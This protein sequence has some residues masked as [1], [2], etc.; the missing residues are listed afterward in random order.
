MLEFIKDIMWEEIFKRWKD[1]EINSGWDVLYKERGFDSWDDWRKSFVDQTDFENQNWKLYKINE[2][3]EFLS[4]SYVGP[5]KGWKIF[6]EKRE[7]SRFK[8]IVK[9]LEKSPHTLNKVNEILNNFPKE[10][11]LFGIRSENRIMLF[12]GSHRACAVTL[13]WIQKITLTSNM[14]VAICDVSEKTFDEFLYNYL[15]S[16]N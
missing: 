1:E 9:N 3:Y 13:A 5:F 4:Q 6:Y 14:E 7:S 10:S 12:E 15:E 16:R 2:P 11:F 8:D